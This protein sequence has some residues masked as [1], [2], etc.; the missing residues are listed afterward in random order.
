MHTGIARPC[1][2]S[3]YERALPETLKM[4]SRIRSF[5]RNALF[6]AIGVMAFI[7]LL[8]AGGTWTLEQEFASPPA[9]FKPWVFYF[10]ENEVM[11]P[12]GITADLEALASAGVG[13]LIVFAEHRED[14][15]TGNVKMFSKEYDAGMRHLLKEAD[16]LGL[17]VSLFG[18]P[19]SSTAGGPWNAV[20]QSMKQFVWSETPLTG[21]GSRTIKLK[22]PF[23]V[24]GYYRDIAVMAYPV[25]ASSKI[26][27]DRQPKISAPKGE[28]NL[29]EMMDGDI[30]TST[31]FRGRTKQEPCEIRLDYPEPI[32]VGRFYVHGNLFNYTEP[33]NY[34]LEVSEDGKTWKKIA[35]MTQVGNNGVIVDFPVVSGRH[36]RILASAKAAGLWIAELDLLPPGGC[37]RSYPQFNDWAASTGRE[38]GTFK[39]YTPLLLGND[40]PLDPAHAVDLG[41]KLQPDGT[42]T[43]DAPPGEWLVLRMG[44][45]STGKKNHPATAEGIG[46]EVDKFDPSLVRRH[47]EEA[48]QHMSGGGLDIPSLKMFH[49]DSWEAGGQTWS[50]NLA[51]EFQRRNGYSMLPFLPVLGAMQVGDADKTRRFLEDFRST[52]RALVAESFYG[53]MREVSKK[54]GLA[55]LAESSAGPIPLHS[56][57][58]YFQ[59]V[60]IPAGEAWSSGNF[61]SDGNISGGLRDAVSG[62]HLLGRPVTPVEVFTSNVGNWNMSP[63]FLKAFGDK[64]LATGANQLMMHCYIH[65][66]STDPA[67]GWTMNHYGTTLNRHVTWWKQAAP[68]LQSIARSQVMLRQGRSVADFCRLIRDDEAI[69][70]PDW[71]D[72]Q[73]FWDA[74]AGYANDWAG[75]EN[76]LKQLGVENGEI[77]ASSG[78]ARYRLLVLPE[79][80][81]MALDAAK[82]LHELVDAGGVILGPKPSAREGLQ[83][84]EAA[85]KEFARLVGELWGDGSRQDRSVGKGRVL[86][87]MTVDAALA[88]LNVKPD[89]AWITGSKDPKI[90]WHHRTDGRREVY[91]LA[92]G[93]TDTFRATISFRTAGRAPEIWDPQTGGIRRPAVFRVVDGR[94][95]LPVEIS[96]S[97]SLFVVFGPDVTGEHFENV[98]RDGQSLW[99]QGRGPAPELPDAWI[100]PDGS[101]VMEATQPGEYGFEDSRGKTV[102]CRVTPIPSPLEIKGPWQ[103]SFEGVAKPSPQ[104]FEHLIP[105]NTH[106]DPAVR[107]FS[108]TG[109]Y[110]AEF[111]VPPES[112]GGDV[113]AWLDLGDVRELAEVAINGKPLGVAWAPPFRL[114]VTRALHPGKNELVVRAVNTWANRLIGDAALPE[115]E[116]STWTSFTHYKRGDKLPDSGLLGPVQIE[117]YRRL[118]LDAKP[119]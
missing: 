63:R 15:K 21:G 6:V 30:L 91:F 18:C 60:D 36:F 112:L 42:L 26:P 108:G 105:W 51:A 23:T 53:V 111:N 93:G 3:N 100:Q 72:R 115:A 1:D 70:N 95:E 7:P 101:F 90:F 2:T 66:P 87:G 19:G 79:S 117:F 22:Q 104:V 94:T 52:I 50:A 43:W 89:L 96:P 98:T 10:F 34:E 40:K 12:P 76:L 32:E 65:Q 73:I 106:P 4:N 69:V 54:H 61:T 85:D 114:D 107:F 55:F 39:K 29:G 92:N 68:W 113:I 119:R 64:I 45:T 58:D 67:P 14:M 20:E 8:K 31:L 56:P 83:G 44:Y 81:R 41:A 86:S 27:P 37:P 109:E 80:D 24:D 17:M 49:A 110:H 9:Q 82:K 116:R 25:A 74:P 103:V 47:A 46:F 33:L 5:V 97:E 57:L 75:R 16:R 38:K 11:D 78:A 99:P 13:G 118:L 28:G 71:G 48:L 88:L 77:V 62:S 84:G 59:Y 35:A 102:T